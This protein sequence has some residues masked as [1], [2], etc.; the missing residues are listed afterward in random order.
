MDKKHTGAQLYTVREF[1]KN[2]EDFRRT[3]RKVKEIGY[4][5]V[6]VSAIG[7][8]APERVKAAADEAGLGICATHIGFERLQKEL[9]QVIA[10]HRLWNCRYVGL[11]SMPPQFRSSK[12][13]YFAFVKEIAP[14]A[15]RL[16]AEGLQFVY[17]N[18]R[19]EFEKFDGER[20]GLDILIEE[21]D[22]NAFGIELDVFW[23]Q[24]GGGQVTD[25]IRKV[26]G[27]MAVVHLKDMA[28]VEDKAV[29]AEI[30]EGNMNIRDI[31]NACRET[32]VEWYVVEQDDC[33]RDP[34]ESLAISYR[35]LS[36]D[37]GFND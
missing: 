29:T 9:D 37:I 16:R 8:I 24:A 25:W 1:T 36:G 35:R 27:R 34:F 5:T 4:E 20:T 7:P 12:E 22:P 19:F 23:A 14:I 32:G 6:Q 31:V 21:T 13:G 17:H 2:E 15:E 26:K 33:R 30:G 18:H 3:L 10:E 28:I 11:G